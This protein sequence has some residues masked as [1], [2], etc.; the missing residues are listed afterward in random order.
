MNTIKTIDLWTE[1][2]ENQYEGFNSIEIH[3]FIEIKRELKSF[4]ILDIDK[5][6]CNE[7]L[8]NAIVAIMKI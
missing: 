1:P 7:L 5:E 6:S 8:D 2:K 4:E 3:K